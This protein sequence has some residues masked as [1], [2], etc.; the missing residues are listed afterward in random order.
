MASFLWISANFMRV[1]IPFEDCIQNGA[2]A[3]WKGILL[4]L[5]Q[6]ERKVFAPRS[7]L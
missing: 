6:M 2:G 5:V 1:M 3:T 7:I 4:F